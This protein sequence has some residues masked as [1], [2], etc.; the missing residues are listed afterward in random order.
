MVVYF[1]LDGGSWAEF[2]ADTGFDL[3][4]LAV[5]V[6]SPPGSEVP[7]ALLVG[8]TESSGLEEGSVLVFVVLLALKVEGETDVWDSVAD[9]E[10]SFDGIPD[11]ANVDSIGDVHPE[12][13][14]VDVVFG[15]T[16]PSGDTFSSGG[17]V[18]V[19]LESR[20][21]VFTPSNGPPLGVS[22]FL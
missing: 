17:W 21:G 11:I 1:S 2:S 20:S 7:F 4:G 9:S 5:S 16:G 19:D 6:G 10:V 13:V 22:P 8:D 18:V 3:R 12:V 14:P 15:V